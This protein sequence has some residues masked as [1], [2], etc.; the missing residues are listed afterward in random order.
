MP[1]RDA[2]K[3]A[4]ISAWTS[5]FNLL[6]YVS[7]KHSVDSCEKS[8]FKRA[9]TYPKIMVEL[10]MSLPLDSLDHLAR[11]QHMIEIGQTA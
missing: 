9:L 11:Q 8:F 10:F 7:A 3:F 6:V 5:G 2:S 1:N 4:K